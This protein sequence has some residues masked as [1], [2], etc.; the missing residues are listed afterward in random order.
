MS[1][2][3]TYLFIIF[4]FP[5]FTYTFSHSLHSLVIRTYNMTFSQ[6]YV[7]S[8]F[9]F[10]PF[11]LISMR[12]FSY[13]LSLTSF[14]D[15]YQSCFLS[16]FQLLFLLL[17][18]TI[19]CSFSRSSFPILHFLMN[20]P[21]GQPT[22]P[23]RLSIVHLHTLFPFYIYLSFL[24][25]L[26]LIPSSLS[27]PITHSFPGLFF[28]SFTYSSN[29]SLIHAFVIRTFNGTFLQTSISSVYLFLPFFL[30]FLSSFLIACYN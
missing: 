10:S 3:R 6:V 26:K 2:P 12:L 15:T 7:S 24:I 29:H 11:F 30:I 1:P 18:F 28:T 22:G 23:F 27:S 5:S 17:S 13:Y 20:S 25:S 14:L 4:F 8:L 19:F 16:P 21:S 9:F